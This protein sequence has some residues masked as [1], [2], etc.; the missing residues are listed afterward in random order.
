VRRVVLRPGTSLPCQTA[1]C[2]RRLCPPA[3]KVGRFD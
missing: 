3:D 1:E 2:A